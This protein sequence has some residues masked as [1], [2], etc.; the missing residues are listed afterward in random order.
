METLIPTINRL[1]EVFLTVG[2]EIIQLPQIVVVGSQVSQEQKK[3][4]HNQKLN[5][6]LNHYL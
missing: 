2:T 1:Q 4:P 6:K 5:Y 3:P